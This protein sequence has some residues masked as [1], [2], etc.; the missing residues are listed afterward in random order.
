MKGK[1]ETTIPQRVYENLKITYLFENTK[2]RELAIDQ[3]ITDCVT[4]NSA[5]CKKYVET[6]PDGE[7]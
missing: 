7:E 2:E 1:V 6:Y 4:Y 3:A 5:V